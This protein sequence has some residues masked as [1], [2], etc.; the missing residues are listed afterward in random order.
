[1]AREG[2]KPEGQAALSKETGRSH[3]AY[4]APDVGCLQHTQHTRVWQAH[5]KDVSVK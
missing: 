3:L 4:L 2:H 1:M 5:K